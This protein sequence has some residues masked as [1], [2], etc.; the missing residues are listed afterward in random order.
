LGRKR[1]TAGMEGEPPLGSD[2]EATKCDV[3]GGK[4]SKRRRTRGK[5]SHPSWEGEEK[6]GGDSGNRQGLP[7]RKPAVRRFTEEKG[8]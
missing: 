4:N 5:R 2:F 3:A 1:E 8:R 6:S 7:D